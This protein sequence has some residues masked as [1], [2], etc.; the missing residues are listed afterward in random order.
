[1][2]Q[3]PS[4]YPYLPTIHD[5]LLI[6]FDSISLQFGEFSY[7]ALDSVNFVFTFTCKVIVLQVLQR[8]DD[9]SMMC[10]KRMTSLKRLALK[11]PRP[12]QTVTP[13]PA[14][15]F[16]QPSCGAPHYLHNHHGKTNNKVFKK[17]N[18]LPKVSV[19]SCISFVVHTLS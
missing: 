14:V 9:V 3:S 16:Q 1:M 17:A 18:T 10:E 2:G 8:I 15:P 6:S 19:T 5:H 13:E 7:I 11:L 4:S 12:V